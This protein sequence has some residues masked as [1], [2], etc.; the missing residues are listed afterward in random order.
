[1]AN[2][3]DHWVKI[4]SGIWESAASIENAELRL[5]L[6]QAHKDLDIR[7]HEIKALRKELMIKK[8]LLSHALSDD[9][10]ARSLDQVRHHASQATIRD[11]TQS[12]ETLQKLL[13]GYRK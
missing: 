13:N 9:P 2:V 3:T 11:L 5:N 8:S 6:K 4:R 10:I 12:N 7:G 1:M